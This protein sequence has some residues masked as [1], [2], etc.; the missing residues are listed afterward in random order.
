MFT[1]NNLVTIASIIVM[2]MIL[3]CRKEFKSDE[4]FYLV[5]IID[6]LILMASLKEKFDEK[7]YPNYYEIIPNRH[8]NKFVRSKK[9][10]LRSKEHNDFKESINNRLDKEREMEEVDRKG[11]VFKHEMDKLIEMGNEN[12]EYIVNGENF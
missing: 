11:M 4:L 5:L 6:L 1:V 8:P 2:L 12:L 9:C 3:S 10:F 7:F